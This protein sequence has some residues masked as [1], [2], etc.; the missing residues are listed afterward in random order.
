MI[1]KQAQNLLRPFYRPFWRYQRYP[2]GNNPTL[3]FPPKDMTFLW[4]LALQVTYWQIF[5]FNCLTQAG[6]RSRETSSRNPYPDT[7]Q[8]LPC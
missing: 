1:K 3:W 4:T 2:I 5:I 6:L 7:R 8:P